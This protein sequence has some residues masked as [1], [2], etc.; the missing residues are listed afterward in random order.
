M[1]QARTLATPTADPHCPPDRAWPCKSSSPDRLLHTVAHTVA[2]L[3][4]HEHCTQPAQPHAQELHVWLAVRSDEEDF[5]TSV[6][7]YPRV[8]LS[9]PG[10]SGY[11]L[12]YKQVLRAVP[13]NPLKMG[14]LLTE[15]MTYPC[16]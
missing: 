12:S 3:G 9:T 5:M 6:K 11:R 14:Y 16:S 2:Q 8:V 10:T 7:R 1:T 15:A 4:N 13:H